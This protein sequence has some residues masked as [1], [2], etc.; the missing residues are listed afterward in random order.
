MAIINIKLIQNS[1]SL[2]YVDSW[3]QYPVAQKKPLAVI[4]LNQEWK[5]M[6]NTRYQAATAEKCTLKPVFGRTMIWK[7]EPT[8]RKSVVDVLGKT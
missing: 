2:K 1:V 6:L 4:N 8:L 3:T 7:G 5:S